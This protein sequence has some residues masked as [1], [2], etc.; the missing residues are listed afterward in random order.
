MGTENIVTH[1]I[2]ETMSLLIQHN[3]TCLNFE[4]L[5]EGKPTGWVGDY[6]YNLLNLCRTCAEMWTT[7]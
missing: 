4:P 7:F 1:D 3:I 6:Y 2:N 5:K